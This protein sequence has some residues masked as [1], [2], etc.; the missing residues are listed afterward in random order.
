MPYS[1]RAVMG[2]GEAKSKLTFK[3]KMLKF[4]EHC[5]FD[6]NKTNDCYEILII[7]HNALISD[8]INKIHKL[9]IN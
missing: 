3:E 2:L 9:E 5:G 8:A 6:A 1:C 4:I 7:M